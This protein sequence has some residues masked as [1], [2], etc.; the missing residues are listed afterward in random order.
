MLGGLRR[1]MKSKEIKGLRCL[2]PTYQ[3]NGPLSCKV[4]KAGP[5]QRVEGRNGMVYVEEDWV[6]EDRTSHREWDE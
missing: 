1:I 5:E 6:D 2:T 3:L 4:Y